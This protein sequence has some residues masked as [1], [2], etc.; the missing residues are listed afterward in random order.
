MKKQVFD[1][2]RTLNPTMVYATICSNK[3]QKISSFKSNE[4]ILKKVDG[5]YYVVSDI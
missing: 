5:P 2:K 4:H 1:S 3:I